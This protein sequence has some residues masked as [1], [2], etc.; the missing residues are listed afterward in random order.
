MTE[1][2]ERSIAQKLITWIQIIG[3]VIASSWGV[4]TF[5]YKEIWLPRAAPVN[6]TVD[7]HLKKIE[8]PNSQLLKG[9]DKALI[10]VEMAVSATNPSSREVTLFPSVWIA[11]GY[12]VS[13]LR[14]NPQ[15]AEQV[16]SSLNLEGVSQVEK[17]AAVYTTSPDPVAIGRLFP[18]TA[19]KPNE[20]ATRRIV[21]HV[22]PGQYDLI[23]VQVYVPTMTKKGG[24]TLEWKYDEKTK[25][26]NVIL[27]RVTKNGERKEME[28]DK[29]GGYSDTTLELQ[30]VTSVSTLSLWQ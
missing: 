23:D 20:K 3:I 27:Y 6:V 18:D 19:L 16:N 13:A 28:K 12:N 29:G 25:S 26:L 9:E 24:A 30:S 1:S 14:K 5:I 4:Y 21:F 2:S 10:A 7:L 17:H 15:F 11:V 8:R 22:P